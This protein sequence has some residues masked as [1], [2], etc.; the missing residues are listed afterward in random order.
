[1][2]ET[3][4]GFAV[5]WGTPTAGTCTGT[6]FS[7]PAPNWQSIDYKPECEVKD[8]PD[9]NGSTK[10]RIYYNHGRRVTIDVLPASAG[11]GGSGALTAASALMVLPKKG[12]IVTVA[13]VDADDQMT[14]LHSGVWILEEANRKRS[15][16]SETMI[17]FTLYQNV[18]NNLGVAMA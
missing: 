5:A 11:T 17:T 18:D 13:S 7:A 1:M 6:G 4:V 2:A 15:N 14:D 16:T 8:I 12:T 3:Q 9:A 10:G